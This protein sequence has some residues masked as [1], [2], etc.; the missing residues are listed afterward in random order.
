MNMST[1]S[2]SRSRPRAGGLAAVLAASALIVLVTATGARAATAVS[3]FPIPGD[4][5]ATRETQIVIRGLPS[6]QFGT[7]TVTGSESGVHTGVVK[8]DSDGAGGSFIPTKPFT[9][10]ERVTVKTGLD[11]TGGSQ[12]SWSFTVE[13]P[14]HPA[15]GRPLKIGTRAKGDVWTFATE[16]SLKPASVEVIKKPKG[17]ADGDLFLAPQAGPYE[18]GVEILN[19]VGRLVY[20]KPVPHGQNATDFSVQSFDGQSDLTWWQ[21]DVTA[22]GT[23][24]GED[25]IYNSSYQHVATVRAG[26]GLRSDLHEFLLGSSGTAWVTAYQPV[27]WNASKIKHGSKREV[28]L[29]AVAQEIDIKTGLVLYQWD[30][31]DHVALG[32][33]YAP[34]AKSGVPWDYFHINSIQPESNGSVVVSSRNT[35]AVYELSGQTGKIQWT[36]GGKFSSFKLGK[37]V[38]FFYQHDARIQADGQLTLF[39]DGGMPFRESESRALAINLDAKTNTA[40]VVH[41][42]THSP[43]LRAPAEGSV[44]RLGNGD[45]LVGWGQAPDAATEFNAQGKVVFDAKFVGGNS[46]YR[47]YRFPWTGTPKTRPAIAAHLYQGHTTVSASWNGSTETSRWRIRAGRSIKS[48]KVVA[49]DRKTHYETNMKLGAREGYVEVQALDAK[50]KVLATSRPVAGS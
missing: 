45:E 5:V 41:Q 24:R 37:G 9:A 50:G 15:A 19:S 49:T 18:N 29:D 8:G 48:L 7:I 21:G 26:N 4:R 32:A 47:A 20:F 44:E 46:S 23:G 34:V 22:S 31:L 28:V 30:S 3:V 2:V 11:V 14:A 1:T 42:D 36:L 39:D 35:S 38:R 40:T 17:I 25:E 10:G 43:N 27:I 33:S 12:G 13:T 16:P 6:S